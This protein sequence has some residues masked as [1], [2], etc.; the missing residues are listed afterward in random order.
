M[1]LQSKLML[2]VRTNCFIT[3]FKNDWRHQ[4]DEYQKEVLRIAISK[5]RKT[6]YSGQLREGTKKRMARAIDLLV[7]VST[8]RWVDNPIT[9][10]TQPHR[11]SFITITVSQIKNLTQRQV[12]DSCF[13]HFLQWLRRTQKVNTYIWKVEFQKRG[14]IH[15]HITTPSWIHYQSI[16]DKWN[17]LQ[18]KAGIIDNY[19]REQQAYHKEEFTARPWLYK[20]WNHQ[21]QLAA[22]NKGIKDN[23]TDP[24]STDIHEVKHIKDLSNYLKKEF[25]KSIQN[26]DTDGKVWDCSLN[27]KKIGYYQSEYNFDLLN[28]LIKLKYENKVHEK[29]LEQ[30]SVILPY[31]QGIEQFMTLPQLTEYDNHKTLIRNYNRKKPIKKEK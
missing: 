15:Y 7:Q 10:F 5:V 8:K 6:Q 17:N 29:E 31:K 14:Q 11:L 26:P 18:K 24:N 21:K 3:Y 23:W 22:Y 25:C 16:R 19:R 20:L 13:K 9:G 27:L 28:H 30:C 4:I 1:V 2:Q 12:Y